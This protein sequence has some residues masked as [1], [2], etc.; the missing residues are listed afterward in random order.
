MCVCVSGGGGSGKVSVGKMKGLQ[1]KVS[2]GLRLSPTSPSIYS[3][4]LCVYVLITEWLG[5]RERYNKY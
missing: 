4:G 1:R 5:Q 3:D 2:L